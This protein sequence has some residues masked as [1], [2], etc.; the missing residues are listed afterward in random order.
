MGIRG[1]GLGRS[2]G[3]QS[4]HQAILIYGGYF[5]Y[6]SGPGLQ[7][8]LSQAEK[9]DFYLS[10]TVY[11]HF[12][13]LI[14]LLKPLLDFLIMEFSA[15]TAAFVPIGPQISICLMRCYG[16]LLTKEWKIYKET[17]RGNSKTEWTY[18]QWA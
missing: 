3:Q 17:G 11:S 2:V 18:A 15:A 9:N 8:L 4:R 12:H 6:C 14:C 16:S 13:D 5:L 1:A 7:L 10:N